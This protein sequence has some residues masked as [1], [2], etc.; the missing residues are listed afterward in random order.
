[1]TESTTETPTDLSETATTAPAPTA[2][3]T[4]VRA[5]FTGSD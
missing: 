1:M 3:A 2:I 5:G 4:A